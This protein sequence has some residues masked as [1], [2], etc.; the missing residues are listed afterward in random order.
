MRTSSWAL[1]DAV[2]IDPDLMDVAR[3]LKEARAAFLGRQWDDAERKFDSL[4]VTQAP[5][6]DPGLVAAN[7]L[8]RIAH[9]RDS[10]PPDDWVGAF[11]AS[12]K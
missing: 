8:T 10:P 11:V 5:G 6:F 4:A 2:E 9:Y 1:S 3:M 12:E 7:Y